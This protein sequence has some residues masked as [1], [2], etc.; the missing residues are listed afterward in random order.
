MV[1]LKE[2]VECLNFKLPHKVHLTSHTGLR[3]AVTLSCSEEA[4]IFVSRMTSGALCRMAAKLQ[5]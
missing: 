5:H 2:L 4:A 3:L 1:K